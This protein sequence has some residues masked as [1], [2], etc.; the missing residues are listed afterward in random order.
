[1]RNERERC[2]HELQKGLTAQE[3]LRPAL[4]KNLGRKEEG[5]ASSRVERRTLDVRLFRPT[6]FQRSLRSDICS[7]GFLRSPSATR[8][9]PSGAL[10]HLKRLGSTRRLTA[11]RPCLATGLP[12]SCAI[13]HCKRTL[14]SAARKSASAADELIITLFQS[15]CQHLI[16]NTF[17]R[18]KPRKSRQK[19]DK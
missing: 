5:R 12:L 6:L 10:R 14:L 8:Q 16:F 11:L 9:S 19:R 3:W 4:Q 7:Y 18:Q 1:M 15:V 17:A 13:V 2:N